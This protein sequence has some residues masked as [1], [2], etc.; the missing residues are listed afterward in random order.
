MSRITFQIDDSRAIARIQAVQAAAANM[1]PVFA[2][3]GRVIANRIRL[4]F[5]LG[6]DPWGSPWARLKL[7]RGQPLRD[8]G[9]LQRSITSRPDADGVTIGTNVLYARTHQFG[10]EIEAKNAK[11]LMFRAGSRWFKLKRVIVPR[12]AFL[13]L[14]TPT[15]SVALPVEW[16]IEVVRALRAYFASVTRSSSNVR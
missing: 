6:V 8:T 5:R 2:T 13:P 4:C 7:R 14:R 3:I 10:A 16:S 15:S 11:F 9:R 12:R 1:R